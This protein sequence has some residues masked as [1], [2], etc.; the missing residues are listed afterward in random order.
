VATAVLEIRGDASSVRRM[1]GELDG[2]GRRVAAS[3]S[4]AFARS[5][6]EMARAAREAGR[7][8]SQSY[9]QAAQA[10]ERG[11]QAGVR[12]EQRA[13]AVARAEVG[14][15]TGVYRTE[16]E[17]AKRAADDVARARE[18]AERRV[19]ATARR[20]ADARAR[21]ARGR[22]LPGGG[23][24]GQP[25]GR[26]P[27]IGGFVE[28][29]AGAVGQFA[30]AAH[31]QIQD[32]RQ[33]RAASAHTMN[34]ALFQAGAG[35][36]EAMELRRRMYAFA[37]EHGLDSGAVAEAANASQTEFSTLGNSRSTQAER[38]ANVDN[39]LQTQLF[40]RNTGQ[41]GA[42]VAR[43]QGLL[44]NT[45][46]DA[47]AQRNTLLALTGMAQRGAIELGAVTRT[48]M[49]PLQA[50]MA[51]SLIGVDPNDPAARAHAQQQAALQTFAEM[52]VGRGLG[53]SPRALGNIT[54]NMGTA[55]NQ[56]SVQGDM[57]HNI[58][59][60]S[61]SRAQRERLENQLFVRDSHGRSLLRGEYSSTLGLARGLTEAGIDST[62]AQNIFAGTGQG[63][64]QSLQANY[65]RTVAAFMGEGNENVARMMA[66]AGSDF[67]ES[68]VARG[69]GL[70]G[71]EDQ[72][73]L[74]RDQETHDNALVGNTG[75]LNELSKSF[76][77]FAAR[78]PL[79]TSAGGAAA[80]L[81]GGALLGKAGAALG[82]AAVSGGGALLTTAGGVA[83]AGG[84]A[85]AGVMLAGGILAAG[86]GLGA[87]AL[88]TSG[89]DAGSEALG[90]RTQEQR[91]G[92]RDSIF[93]G[94]TWRQLGTAIAEAFGRNPPTVRVSPADA[95]ALARQAGASG[96][97]R[98][99]EAGR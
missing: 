94:E 44:A 61:L 35:G 34:E 24:P 39:F 28:R 31:G 99:P 11:A 66:G 95:A 85:G 56:Q 33:R 12:A 72:T 69:A 79:L 26:R 60:S 41:N 54:A 43:V 70:F 16:A 52:E 5:N 8:A 50:R 48:A 51:Q 6:R 75:A 1:L 27:A 18:T 3:L 13:T 84:A 91:G 89:I 49:A 45:G 76:A 90:G 19:T 92:N 73:A 23:A 37:Q 63:N 88:L 62:Q 17:A 20:E 77:A 36:A 96:G 83:A 59:N 47:G 87:G 46:M 65:R 74:Q 53:M 40:A 98:P 86:A 57:L 58:R 4:S 97:E 93:S 22:F 71:G 81:V 67:T 29:G 14:A 38:R 78:N 68:D 42:E 2:D 32:A 7:A 10:K 15:R 30:A 64:K 80:G 55:L 82:G 9:A 21:D 25:G